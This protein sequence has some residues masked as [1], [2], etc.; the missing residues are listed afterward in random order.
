ML[1]LSLASWIRYTTTIVQA[2]AATA[3][4]KMANRRTPSDGFQVMLHHRQCIRLVFRRFR[5]GLTC[6]LTRGRSRSHQRP[7]GA[8]GC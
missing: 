3:L 7:S 4:L 2:T 8:A 1:S 6:R 5:V